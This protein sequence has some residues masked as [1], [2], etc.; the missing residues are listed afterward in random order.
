MTRTKILFAFLMGAASLMA[1]DAPKPQ[2]IYCSYADERVAHMG[3]NFCELIADEGSTPQVVAV[4]NRDCHFAEEKKGVYEI[5]PATVA[6]LQEILQQNSINNIDGYNMDSHI[7]GGHEYRIHVEYSSGKKIHAQW[8]T[9][10]PD[11]NAVAAY[12]VIEHFFAPWMEKLDMGIT[13]EHL[14]AKKA[15]TPRKGKSINYNKVR[16]HIRKTKKAR[17]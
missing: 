10:S 8:H 5:T 11:N 3:T 1:Q 13:E 9:N 2:L 16:K 6:Q 4:K 7:E 14:K 15:T 12:A 17:K